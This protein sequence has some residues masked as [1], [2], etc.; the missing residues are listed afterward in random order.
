MR[1]KKT[2]TTESASKRGGKPYLN[3]NRYVQ[4]L[5]CPKRLWLACNDPE[6]RIEPAP[7]TPMAVGIEVGIAARRFV[8][9]GALVSDPAYRHAEAI[10]RTTALMNDPTV[11]AIFEAAFEFDGIRIRV[12]IL[13][14]RHKGWRLREVKSTTK[15][16]SEHLDDLAVQ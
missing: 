7:G 9:G 13:E 8:P 1:A 12:D 14:R 3:K 2:Y 16:K 10:A 5:Q 11:P 15:V 4:G 6:P